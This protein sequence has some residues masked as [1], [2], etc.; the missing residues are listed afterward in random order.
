[1]AWEWPAAGLP[2]GNTR[3]LSLPALTSTDL[4]WVHILERD[5]EATS[6]ESR[7]KFIYSVCTCMV[8]CQGVL[9]VTQLQMMKW[10]ISVWVQHWNCGK[11]WME[12]T[13]CRDESCHITCVSVCR[14]KWTGP[15]FPMEPSLLLVNG[16]ISAVLRPIGVAPELAKPLRCAFP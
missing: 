16:F 13:V 4:C 10:L 3:F 7:V 14:C 12:S 15:D 6:E 11:S 2:W 1:M 9:L 8:G 5:V